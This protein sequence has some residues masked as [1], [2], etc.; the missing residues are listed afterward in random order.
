MLSMFSQS[1]LAYS[2]RGRGPSPMVDSRYAAML[3]ELSTSAVKCSSAEAVRR[4]RGVSSGA[5]T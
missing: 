1:W 2:S 4:Y 5:S 3:R